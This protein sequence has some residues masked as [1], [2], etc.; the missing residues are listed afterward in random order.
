MSE[1]QRLD[2]RVEMSEHYLGDLLRCIDWKPMPRRQQMEGRML[3][4]RPEV[5]C[6]G[7]R[8]LPR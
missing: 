6:L 5:F 4:M 1:A 3:Q 7:D 8:P 2:Y